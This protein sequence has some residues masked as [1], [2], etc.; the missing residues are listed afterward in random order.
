MKGHAREWWVFCISCVLYLHVREK[1]KVWTWEYM[2]E[3][4][5]LCRKYKE[6]YRFG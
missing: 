1:R 5:R 4:R 6:M 3:Y 2:K